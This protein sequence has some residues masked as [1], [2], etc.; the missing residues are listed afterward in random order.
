M[1]RFTLP[2]LVA[3]VFPLM[4][5]GC[6]Q[7]PQAP[8]SPDPV[9]ISYSVG[10][11][12]GTCP[13]YQVAVEADGATYFNGERHTLVEGTRQRSNQASVFQTVRSNLARYQPDMGVTQSTRD[14]DPR[15]TDMPQYTV[16]WTTA[17]FE[18]AVLEHDAGCHSDSGRELTESLRSLDGLLG[19]DIWVRATAP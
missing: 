5:V 12:Y 10:P 8:D 14:C 3:C 18:Q 15:A 2:R 19:V 16:V 4:M 13:V 17:A 9:R 7:H 11:C 6:A 1:S